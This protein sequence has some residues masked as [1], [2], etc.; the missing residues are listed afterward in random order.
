MSLLCSISLA[1]QGE[2]LH[3]LKQEQQSIIEENSYYEALLLNK[4][5]LQNIE[6]YAQEAGMMPWGPEQIIY[7]NL[8]DEG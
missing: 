3:E 8:P 5:S 1:A 6:K 4:Y 7:I 2:K